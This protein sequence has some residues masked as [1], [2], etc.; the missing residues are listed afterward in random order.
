MSLIFFISAIC[1]Y[2]CPSTMV[3]TAILKLKM[4]SNTT[5]IK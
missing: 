2:S 1:L 4:T 3:S 5:I